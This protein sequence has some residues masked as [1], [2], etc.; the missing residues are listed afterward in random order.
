[1]FAFSRRPALGRLDSGVSLSLIDKGGFML[2]I[3]QRL[4]VAS[5]LLFSA[6]SFAQSDAYKAGYSVGQKFGSFIGLALPV[7]AASILI[8]AALLAYRAWRKRRDASDRKA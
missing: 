7:A 3:G 5:L 4:S 6:S 1:M 8:V 2:R